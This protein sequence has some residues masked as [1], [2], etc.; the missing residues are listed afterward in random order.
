[1]SL[2]REMQKAEEFVINL[3]LGRKPMKKILNLAAVRFRY[4]EPWR[5][6]TARCGRPSISSSSG[7]LPSSSPLT[8]VRRRTDAE[9]ARVKTFCPRLKIYRSDTGIVWPGACE[10]CSVQRLQILLNRR[11]PAPQLALDVCGRRTD[12]GTVS[13][14]Q[15]AMHIHPL[16]SLRPPSHP[17]PRR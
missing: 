16:H 5:H 3:P 13:L 8:P 7:T 17:T 14:R 2:W 1:M 6:S 4:T 10:E 12:V 15:H 11:S 9:T